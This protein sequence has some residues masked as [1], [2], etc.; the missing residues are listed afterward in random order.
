[1]AGVLACSA[2]R[3]EAISELLPAIGEAFGWVTAT[4]GSGLCGLANRVEA[5]AG[6]LTVVSE[7]GEG[8]TVRAELPLAQPSTIPS[9]KLRG[10]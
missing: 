5:L 1:M 8:T 2:T 9:A 10:V 4:G 6:R 3:D 7:R